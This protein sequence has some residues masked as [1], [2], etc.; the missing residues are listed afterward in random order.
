MCEAPFRLI[1][2]AC[3][4]Y[5]F[6]YRIPNLSFVLRG[7]RVEGAYMCEALPAWFFLLVSFIFHQYRIPILFFVLRGWRTEG[8][9]GA[10]PVPLLFFSVSFLF[11]N[12]EYLIFLLSCADGAQRG[13]QTRTPSVNSPA[14]LR[15]LLGLVFAYGSLGCY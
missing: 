14:L 8:V 10:K 4:F 2:L 9:A 11:T 7:R 1:F 3:F 12:I 5:L 13:L 6:R 15:A